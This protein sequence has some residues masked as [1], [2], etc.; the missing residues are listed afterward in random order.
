MSEAEASTELSVEPSDHAE[1][2]AGAKT[3]GGKKGK[4]KL[5]IIVAVLLIVMIG[6][7]VFASGVLN[8]KAEG[9]G[10]HEGQE[11]GGHAD[12]SDASAKKSEGAKKK[13]AKGSKEDKEKK[14]SVFVNV[15]DMA[16]NLSGG[17]KKSSFLKVKISLEVGDA[18]YAKVVENLMPR[19][20]DSF[21]LYLRQLRLEDLQGSAGMYRLREEL[22]VRVNKI[23]DP[24]EVKDVLFTEFLAQ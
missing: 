2:E 6:G 16:V 14:P 5:I 7:G 13:E 11:E 1:G 12:T 17:G 22:L 23:A 18:E 9:E 21:Q 8:K 10:T 20:I 19:I 24:A 15:P 4:G 3:A